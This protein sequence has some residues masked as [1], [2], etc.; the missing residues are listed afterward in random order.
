MKRNGAFSILELLVVTAVI[1][2]LASLLL[3][4]LS[5]AKESGRRAACINN[6]HQLELALRLF[7][8]E[9]DSRYPARS[10]SQHW[11]SQLSGYFSSTHVLVCPSDPAPADGVTPTPGLDPTDEAPRSY[12]LNGFNDPSVTAFTEESWQGFVQGLAHGTIN[13]SAIAY[14]ADTIL[15]GEKITGSGLYRVDLH[16]EP[17]NYLEAIEHTRHPNTS[18]SSSGGRPGGSNYAY[19][20]GSIHYLKYGKSTCP[21]NLWGITDYWRTNYAACFF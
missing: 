3:P 10:D 7:A 18:G 6:Q 5:R 12:V 15:F 2:L 16:W 4:V 8:D 13:E 19:A 1:A 11:P 14:P 17:G 21:V 20:D 9:N